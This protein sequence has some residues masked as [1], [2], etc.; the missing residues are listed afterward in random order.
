MADQNSSISTDDIHI[1]I[2][3]VVF[4]PIFGYIIFSRF[5]MHW[6]WAFCCLGP[7]LGFIPATIFVLLRDRKTKHSS[8]EVFSTTTPSQEEMVKSPISTGAPA[9]EGVAKI[10]ISTDTP[11]YKVMANIEFMVKQIAAKNNA[12]ELIDAYKITYPDPRV[13]EKFV[14]EINLA[15][16]KMKKEAVGPLIGALKENNLRIQ[17]N[18]IYVLGLIGDKGAVKPLIVRMNDTRPEI[19]AIIAFT[20]GMI[21]SDGWIGGQPP[22]PKWGAVERLLN[23]LKDPETKVRSSAASALGRFGDKRAIDPLIEMLKDTDSQ[24][25]SCAAGALGGSGTN[26]LNDP[27]SVEPLIKLLKDP[28]IS[29]RMVAIQSLDDIGDMRAKEPLMDCRTNDPSSEVRQLA[30]GALSRLP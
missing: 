10:P 20:L 27:R 16:G 26:K 11:S 22:E 8:K 14:S 23:Y 3:W 21:A 7:V 29:V 12:H 9:Q 13:D 30:N 15:L 25:R 6:G 19:R 2:I 28:D 1:F 17:Y 4:S 5:H 24:V 18:A